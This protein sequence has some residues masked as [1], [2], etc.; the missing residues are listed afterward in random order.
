MS[1]D[2]RNN[3]EEGTS[4]HQQKRDIQYKNVMTMNSAILAAEEVGDACLNVVR[5]VEISRG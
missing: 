1:G 5:L 2:Q 3:H 4:K